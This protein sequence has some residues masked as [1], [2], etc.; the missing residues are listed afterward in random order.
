LVFHEMTSPGI[1]RVT[2]AWQIMQASEG[3]P[4]CV[5]PPDIMRFV[6]YPR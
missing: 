1:P 5:M 3:A 4:C 2:S 6:K